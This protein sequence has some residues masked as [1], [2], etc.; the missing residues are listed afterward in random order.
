[1]YDL[2]QDIIFIGAEDDNLD[3]FEAQYP[4]VGGISYNSF[5]INDEKPAIVDGVDIR[6]QEVWLANI[7]E[8][9]R[10]AGKAP[11]YIIIHH[12]EPDHSGGVR[13]LLERYPDLKIVCTAKAADMLANFFEDIDFSE[14]IIKVADG[15]TLSLGSHE[16]KFLTAPMVHWPEVMMTIDLHDKVIFTSDAF[17]SFALSGAVTGWP[18]EARRYYANIVGRFG[19]SVQGIL[20]KIAKE[21]IRII[22]PLHGAVL[23]DNLDKYIRLYDKW[24]RYEAESDGILVAYAS[25]YG[26]T[27]YVAQRVASML[28]AKGASEV[29]L[30]DLCRHDVSYAVAEAWRFSRMVLCSVTY[31]ADVFPAM[32]NFLHHLQ[33]KKL[34]DRTV[35]LIENGSWAPVA[36]N[37]MRKTLDTM[38][39]IHII[40]PVISIRSRLHNADLPLLDQLADA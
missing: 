7:N 12:M 25:I 39:N 13:I 6:R 1:M 29:V 38:K 19:A 14:S 35:A 2:T 3:L 4:L 28:R 16:L 20:K 37:T 23:R 24:S 27:A 18:D 36:A 8:A 10:R 17:G 34:T 9:I 22:A 30:L 26:G 32:H 11:E 31:D 15:D 21:D 33:Q 40:D 5:F